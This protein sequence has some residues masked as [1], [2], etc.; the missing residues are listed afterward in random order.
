MSSLCKT[1][2]LSESSSVYLNAVR[3]EIAYFQPCRFRKDST[4]NRRRRP[5]SRK[6]ARLRRR[7]CTGGADGA[8]RHPSAAGTSGEE[9]HVWYI[10]E[11]TR[12]PRFDIRKYYSITQCANPLGGTCDR[13]FRWAQWGSF[14]DTGAGAVDDVESTRGS[15]GAVLDRVLYR[16]SRRKSNIHDTSLSVL[17]GILSGMVVGV[18]AAPGK[19]AWR[20]EVTVT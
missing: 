18:T 7:T 15:P 4:P 14:A 1:K 6:P 5:G 20:V 16:K 2:G 17:R 11:S 3:S 9:Y 10:N 19:S 12:R 8:R 13:S